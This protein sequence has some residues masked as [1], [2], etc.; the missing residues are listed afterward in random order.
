MTQ[1]YLNIACTNAG[2]LKASLFYVRTFVWEKKFLSRAAIKSAGYHSIRH[3]E[4]LALAIITRLKGYRM[5][6][7]LL[8]PETL[9]EE[10]VIEI[11]KVRKDCIS[12]I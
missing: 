2:M 9:S 7:V 4:T 10:Q 1:Q 5:K 11:W 12:K 8:Q 6:Q 3:W